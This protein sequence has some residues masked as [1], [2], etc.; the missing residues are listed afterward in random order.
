MLQAARD[1]V[2]WPNMQ[3]EIKD[4]VSQCSACNEYA[5][6][7]QRE[8]MSHA[9][10]TRPWQIISMDLFKQ[11]G[12]DFLLMVDHYSDFW[13]IEL[14]PDLSAETTILRCKAQM[15]DMDSL[16]ITDC[17]SQ[18]ACET[19]RKFAKEWD[20]EHVG[21][22]CENSPKSVQESSQCRY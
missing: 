18:L 14:L 6:E 16:T 7:Q 8:T 15:L 22:S 12:K 5:H 3:A 9:L 10:S 13:E 11:A 17:G 1:T 20:F 2:Y 19:F 4:Y 21:V